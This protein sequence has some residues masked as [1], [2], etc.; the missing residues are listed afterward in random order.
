MRWQELRMNLRTLPFLESHVGTSD[1][2][3]ELRDRPMPKLLVWQPEMIDWIFRSDAR[4]RH[5][6]GQS[7]T[8][9]FGESSLLWAE[10]ERHTAYRHALGPSLRG[11]KL[12]EQKEAVADAVHAAIDRLTPGTVVELLPWTRAIALR[13]IARI[14]FG[15]CEDDL[16]T[17]VTQWTERAF[18]ARHRTLVYRYLLGGIPRPGAELDRMLVRAAK[19]NPDLRPRTLAARMLDGDGPLGGI[20]DTELRDAAISLMFA[21]HET[22]AAGAAWALYWL[23]RNPKV[24]NEIREEIAATDADGS[25]PARVPLLAAAVSET[26][27]LTPPAS[28]AEHRVLTEDGEVCG[29]MMAAGTKLT[30]A[31]YLAH[32]DPDVFGHPKRFDPSRFLGGRPPAHHYFPFGGG[33]RYCL[34]SQ[35][36]QLEIR[37]IVAGVLRRREWRCVNPRAGG[38]RMR[39]NVMAPASTLRMRVLTCR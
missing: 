27:R 34:G 15:H 31:I 24:R 3:L 25:D 36:A 19:V 35:L 14:L 20:G 6:G 33:T 18:G 38:P 21:G 1:G 8:P 11:R 17:A 5:P 32:H 7:L 30:P 23:D 9:L 22:T 13:V 28:L 10:G 12:T 2:V 37:M 16:L 29:R 26:L 4:L 39:G